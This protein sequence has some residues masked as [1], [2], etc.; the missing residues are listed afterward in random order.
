MIY[1]RS[2][3]LLEVIDP[4]VGA[5]Y[6]LSW[7]GHGCVWRV[8]EIKGGWVRLETPKTH[9]ERWAKKSDLRH[10]RATQTKIENNKNNRNDKT[11]EGI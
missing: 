5:L 4:K 10:T 11:P 1:S 6:H 3:P 8:K 9:I 2:V 7:A